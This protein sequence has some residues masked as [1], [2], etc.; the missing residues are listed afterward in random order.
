MCRYDILIKSC[1][2]WNSAEHHRED[3]ENVYFY[4][5]LRHLFQDKYETAFVCFLDKHD[6][7]QIQ[8]TLMQ[9]VTIVDRPNDV[10]VWNDNYTY[11]KSLN[12][13]H[14]TR[15]IANLRQPNDVQEY[16]V[17]FANCYHKPILLTINDEK[18]SAFNFKQ[19]V[20][21]LYMIFFIIFI[22]IYAYQILV[23]S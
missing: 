23:L 13:D 10:H 6:D 19:Y 5:P 11:C 3:N 21:H 9:A 1:E 14:T 20:K 12:Q 2:L 22:I 8:I 18:R 17:G 16:I 7:V 4:I 15:F